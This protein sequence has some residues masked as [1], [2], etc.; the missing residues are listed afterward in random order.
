M[1]LHVEKKGGRFYAVERKG[2]ATYLR[3]NRRMEC[4][5]VKG[6][7]PTGLYYD[8]IAARIMQD[9][10]PR[11]TVCILGLGGATIARRLRE[12]GYLGHITGVENDEVML[13]LG[14]EYFDLW[15]VDEIVRADARGYCLHKKVKFDVVINDLYVD[16]NKQ[17]KVYEDMICKKWGLIITNNFPLPGITTRVCT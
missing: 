5:S 3:I 4:Q 9:T 12:L 17:V 2:D 6:D 14:I 1:Y 16:S 11:D 7:G 8:D 13:R 10:P 15:A